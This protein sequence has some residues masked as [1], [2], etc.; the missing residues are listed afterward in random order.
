[1]KFEGIHH[2][3]AI[4]A[5]AQDNV[6][7]YAG[8]LGPAPRQEDRQPGRPERL[9]RLLLRRGGPG[10]LRHHVLRVP[11]RAAR[12]S[13][14]RH[15]PH[16]RLA[17]RIPRRARLLGAAPR[18]QRDRVR[19]RRRL[20]AA[21]PIPRASA[22]ELRV[23]DV[24]DEPLAAEHPEIPAEHALQGFDAVR[25]YASV[26]GGGARGCSASWASRAATATGRRG[27]KARGGWIHY[28]APPEQR[29]MQ[30]AGTVHHVAW[31]STP[32]EHERW[33]E[34][35]IER[36][37]PPDPGDRSL[38]LQVDL[39]PRAERGPVRD[40]DA[41]AR[42]STSTSR[43]STSGRSCRCRRISSTCARRWRRT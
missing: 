15:G 22:H 40:R 9:P 4:T 29:G 24:D 39:L 17:G 37:R 33:R 42:A 41:R 12:P 20:A 31:A 26:A 27:A 16:G 35:V 3:T 7:F 10:R 21:S 5:D 19:A 6:D 34:K 14:R 32:E 25:A 28:D 38:L 8:V 11:G 43:P 13:G 1:M 2:I 23:S 30:G 36:W 18:R